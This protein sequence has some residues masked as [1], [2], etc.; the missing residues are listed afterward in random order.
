MASTQE[1]ETPT[2]RSSDF[3]NKL[4]LRRFSSKLQSF[5]QGRRLLREET[6][7]LREE[8]AR[9]RVEKK[10]RRRAG[11]EETFESK[12]ASSTD[13][14]F[15]VALYCP[16]ILP[17]DESIPKLLQSIRVSKSNSYA[18][19]QCSDSQIQNMKFTNDGIE[20]LT[21]S[22]P[23]QSSTSQ[24]LKTKNKR[25]QFVLRPILDRPRIYTRGPSMRP[26]SAPFDGR[27]FREDPSSPAS[28]LDEPGCLTTDELE[29]TLVRPGRPPCPCGL[30]CGDPSSRPRLSSSVQE[31]SP[32][33]D[34]QAVEVRE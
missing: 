20:S 15:E 7:R 33:K 10:G 6:S 32:S 21:D 27:L 18:P 29:K 3:A 13:D 28:G 30:H 9:L 14:S 5:H 12:L 11:S 23:S 34:E 25:E 22:L 8:N 24:I 26:I 19:S 31:T 2:K 1:V 4:G 16:R 17:E